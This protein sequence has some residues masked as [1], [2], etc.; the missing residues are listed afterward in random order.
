MQSLDTHNG[1]ER[2]WFDTPLGRRLR[3]ME[4]RQFAAMIPGSAAG[5]VLQ[6]P[7]PFGTVELPDV[8]P[9]LRPVLLSGALGNRARHF[10]PANATAL[11]F[12][13]GSIAAALL[14]HTL[15]GQDPPSRVVAEAARVLEPGG[16]MLM[17]GFNPWSLLGLLKLR[18]K[19]WREDA[20]T[21]PWAAHFRSL[22]SMR[23]HLD[24]EDLELHFPELSKT[25]L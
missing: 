6:Y 18:P 13:R 11:P 15:E 5:Y 9:R 1:L 22:S 4:E 2:S 17:S 14:P 3:S 25:G 20:I 24:G 8:P 7:C 19:P 12:A 23:K 10:V 21:G 16:C